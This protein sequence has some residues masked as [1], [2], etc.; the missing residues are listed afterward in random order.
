MAEDVLVAKGVK[1]SKPQ[2][3]IVPGFKQ[4][5]VMSANSKPRQLD[6]SKSV[7]KTT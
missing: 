4:P 2:T 6:E 7:K 3:Y 1:S 5:E